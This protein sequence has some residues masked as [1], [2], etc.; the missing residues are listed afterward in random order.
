MILAIAAA[1]EDANSW[2]QL[3]EKLYVLPNNDREELLAQFERILTSNS[4]NSEAQYSVWEMITSEASRHEKYSKS[5]WAMPAADV[6][7][8]QRLALKIAPIK[9]ARRF[10]N[11]FDWSSQIP[12][13]EDDLPTDESSLKKLQIEAIE[14]VLSQEKSELVSLVD[15]V[16]MPATIGILLAEIDDVPEGIIFEW[17]TSDSIKLKQASFGY[18]RSKSINK[19]FE[20]IL[21]V[22][23]SS[24]LQ[25]TNRR[26]ALMSALPF[27]RE[28]WT[29]VDQLDSELVAA[30]WKEARPFS[31]NLDE[32]IEAIH[33][34]VAHD[35]AWQA[36]A[37]LNFALHGLE[38]DLCNE[39]KS[40]LNALINTNESIEDPSMAGYYIEEAI[41]Y[42]EK[43]A[44][45]DP[46]LASFEF[47]FFEFLHDHE[48]PLLY[49]K[50]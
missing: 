25:I 9:D 40:V 18:I 26:L 46:D 23:N 19:G 35:R 24:E 34:L 28:F 27:S 14:Q 12:Y 16:K 7:T 49:T 48:Q 33:L 13:V 38:T 37:L 43:F 17:L 6:S 36:I 1:G 30:Y 32:S 42:L 15:N 41:K 31:T 20:W 21:D 5:P 4:W 50:R 29:E 44:P 11:L 45:D 47:T 10:S 8:L 2:V 39:V 3:L 22:L